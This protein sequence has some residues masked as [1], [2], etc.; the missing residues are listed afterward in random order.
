MKEFITNTA[1][2]C[3]KDSIACV[4]EIDPK[5]VPDFVKKSNGDFVIKTREWLK[6]K[7]NKGIVYMASRNFM[8]TGS[9]KYN[10]SVGPEG[11]SIGNLTMLNGINEDG[12]A[13]VCYDG[14]I[15]WDNGSDRSEE[16]GLLIGY[17][18]I[19][20]LSPHCSVKRKKKVL[21]KS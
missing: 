18:I 21:K 3:W 6:K 20:D 12:H 11:Y 8:E 14:K 16:Y 10:P 9:T 7:F 5:D 19:Y 2:T 13:V 17:F 15:V 1:D 4:L